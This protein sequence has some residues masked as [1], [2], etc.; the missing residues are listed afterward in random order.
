MNEPL[1]ILTEA[2]ETHCGVSGIPQG[3]HVDIGKQET[4]PVFLCAVCN[5]LFMKIGFRGP[6]LNIKNY[7]VVTRDDGV[8]LIQPSPYNGSEW[9]TLEEAASR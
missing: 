6:L 9:I 4:Y 5:K 8:R 3:E 2:G 1:I 7:S